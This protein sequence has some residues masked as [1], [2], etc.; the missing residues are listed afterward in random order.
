MRALSLIAVVT[1]FGPINDLVSKKTPDHRAFQKT[2]TLLRKLCNLRAKF[3]I[4]GRGRRAPE[5]DAGAYRVSVWNVLA[6]T[7]QSPPTFASD[8]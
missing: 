1:P 5:S 6:M 3:V 2:E 7:F 8:R 4:D